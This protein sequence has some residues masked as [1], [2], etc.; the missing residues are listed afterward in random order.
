MIEGLIELARRMRARL[1]PRAAP[2][3]PN[4]ALL[5]PW[6]TRGA[7]VVTS[8]VRSEI[9]TLDAHSTTAASI[10]R[11]VLPSSAWTS[12]VMPEQRKCELS[13]TV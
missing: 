12:S 6:F 9:T 3:A 2:V 4:P 1:W 13:S 11:W 5:P 7:S 10:H 8:P